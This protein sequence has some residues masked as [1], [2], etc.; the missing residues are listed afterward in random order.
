[1]ADNLVEGPEVAIRN[2]AASLTANFSRGGTATNVSDFVTIP[3]QVTF[4]A[5]QASV[6]LTITPIDDAVVEGP[7]T[8]ILTV[9][10]SGFVVVGPSATATLTIADHE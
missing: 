5:G 9:T 2:L 3:S 10:A 8:V 6:A 1:L 7:E 4:P